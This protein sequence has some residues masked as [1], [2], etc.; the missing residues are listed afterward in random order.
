M[1]LLTRL[2]IGD[3]YKVCLKE[4]GESCPTGKFNNGYLDRGECEDGELR[5]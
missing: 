3:V 2:A 5:L 1:G 4:S